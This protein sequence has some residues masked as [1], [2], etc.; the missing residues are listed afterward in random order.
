MK[1]VLFEVMEP[2]AAMERA[3]ASIKSGKTQAYAR[4]TFRTAESLA[5]T[6]TP[7]RWCVVEAMT[8]TG[9][10]GVREIAR[11]IERDVKAAHNDVTALVMAGIVERTDDGKYLFP[12]DRIKVRFDVSAAA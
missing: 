8:G 3:K 4:H 11:R 7:S 5:R 2:A 6:L 12:F 9:P 10:L 1:T